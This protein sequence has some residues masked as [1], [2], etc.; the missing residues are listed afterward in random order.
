M[1]QKSIIT[2]KVTDA[3][4]MD[5][6]EFVNI[7]IK[8]QAKGTFSDSNGFFRLELPKG[9]YTLFF[10]SV[11]YDRYE[12]TLTVDG[13]TPHVLEVVL[14]PVTKELGTVVVTTSK[15]QQKLQESISSIEV[16]KADRIEF[17]NP[18]S[19]DK[20]IEQIPGITIVDNEPQ[21]RGGSGFSSGLGSRVMIMVDEIPLLRGDAGRPDWG[22]LPVDDVEQIELVKG[23]SS[24]IYGS[25]AITGAINI[26]TTYPKDKPET[27][28]NTF[29]G[30]YS[31]PSRK[32][33]TPWSG[34]NPLQFGF[35]VSHLQKFDNFD[36]GVG[37]SY[38]NDQGY[39]RG[40]PEYLQDTNYNKGEFDK[41]A[42]IYFNTRIRNKKI[43][44][45][46][47]GVNGTFMYSDNAENFFWYD[48]DTNIYRSYPG[49][50]S[51]FKEFS[52][53][54]DPYVKYFNKNGN[55]HSLKNRVY[56][57]NTDAN[58]NQSNRYLTIYDEY[59]FTHKFK[60]VGDLLMV[61]GIMNAY[62]HSYGQVFSGK[63]APDGT[64]T[65]NEPGAYDAENVGV[66]LQLEKKFFKRLTL[67]VGG[68]W[69]YYQINRDGESKPIFRAGLN[70][71]AAKGTFI[72]ASVGQGYRAPSIGEK[73]I[74]TNSGGFGFYP[75]PDLVAEFSTSYELGLK[76]L[77][78]IGKFYGL[79]DAAGFY[80]DYKNY[81]EFNFG[82]WGDN[83]NP[84]KNIG[85]R[86]L[87]T[88][89][90]HIYGADLTFSGQGKIFHNFDLAV[91]IGYTYSV[92]KAVDPDYIYY[93]QKTLDYTYANTST[94]TTGNIMKYR[95]Q[96]LVKSDI[97]ITYRKHLSAGFSGRY[98][99]YMRNIDKFLY[100]LDTPGAMHSGIQKYREDHHSGNF[101]VDFRISYT[102]RDFRFSLL[103]NNL[104][105]TE[106]SLR[107]IT[108]E[109]PR[110]TSLQVVL[111]I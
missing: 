96:H 6:V 97:Q 98:Y 56:Y 88:G 27:K 110:T 106:Y 93:H 68:R 42:K 103:V 87:N 4:T 15:Y 65:L 53:Y 92:P 86:F 72:R 82:L 44:G 104:L 85:F 62:T 80:E 109:S 61:G 26:R 13:K 19:I 2:G 36:L 66:Y 41:R 3:K 89:P 81:I 7:G 84:V 35:S 37:G 24:V 31:K 111:T 71:E 39:I 99:G 78:R 69:E 14:D 55:S 95:I 40:T 38:Y 50:L 52:F 54:V 94:D 21:I 108:I 30:V 47:Y 11:G 100:Q 73:Y 60:K 5:P 51:H 17:Q 18:A 33:A 20:A 48:A 29:L 10:S 23:A 58:N 64:T 107:P 105:N 22:F 12:K 76:Q 77:F 91:L 1:A 75:N 45:L 79:F 83:I 63:L 59:Q 90:T 28:V 74:T 102:L 9:T 25:S 67:L 43:E 46:T 16:L 32:Y 70:L 57:G 34:M 101:I 49:A 8:D